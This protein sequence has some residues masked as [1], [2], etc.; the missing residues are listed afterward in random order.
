MHSRIATSRAVQV[1]TATDAG[2]LRAALTL[3]R[4]GGEPGSAAYTR[5][6]A[7]ALTALERGDFAHAGLIAR[8]VAE[9]GPHHDPAL[10]YRLFYVAR[11]LEGYAVAWSNQSSDPTRYHG[12]HGDFRNE[13][14][15]QSLITHLGPTALPS[16]DASAARLLALAI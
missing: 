3:L 14:I 5:A 1:G 15:L 6:L 10:A 8:I 7:T 16:L 2:D 13:P 9:P 12:P 4:A 11:A